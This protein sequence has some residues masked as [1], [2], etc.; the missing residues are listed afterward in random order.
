MRNFPSMSYCMY[1]NT[2]AHLGQVNE[3]IETAFNEGYSMAEYVDELNREEQYALE[4]MR[5]KC[6]RFIQLYDRLAERTD[7]IVYED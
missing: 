6:K 4:E 2:R 5:N 3:D 1:Q 7:S